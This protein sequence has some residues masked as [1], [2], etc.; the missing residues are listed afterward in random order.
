MSGILLISNERWRLERVKEA[1]PQAELGR[2]WHVRR[3]GVS[4]V[5]L[6]IK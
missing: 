3:T 2:G 4:L 5:K 1:R 6:T